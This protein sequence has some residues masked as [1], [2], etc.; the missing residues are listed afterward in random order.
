[1]RKSTTELESTVLGLFISTVDDAFSESLCVP[2]PTL[3]T[4]QPLSSST[5][6]RMPREELTGCRIAT[7][8][9]TFHTILL[10]W[11]RR[12]QEPKGLTMARDASSPCGI[13][14]STSHLSCC[15][16]QEKEATPVILFSDTDAARTRSATSGRIRKL[17][18]LLDHRS[19]SSPA[20]EYRKGPKLALSA[21][22]LRL[23]VLLSHVSQK[24]PG[25]SLSMKPQLG[26]LSLRARS[27]AR[28]LRPSFS[29]TCR[30][31]AQPVIP[32]RR[33]TLSPSSDCRKELTACVCKARG[34]MPGRCNGSTV[35]V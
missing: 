10:P 4:T 33:C 23:L 11:N 1:M 30:I 35:A 5:T 26:K 19:T 20:I 28:L 24:V 21:G 25:P 14:A 17:S 13:V 9:H 6:S 29:S 18:S 2:D 12:K 34:T 7:S 22:W 32:H 16:R 15:R 3:M 27:R 8:L 31:T